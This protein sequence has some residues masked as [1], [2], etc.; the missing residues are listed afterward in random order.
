MHNFPI[1][2]LF[3]K[4]LGSPLYFF[5]F[6]KFKSTQ[7]KKK[8]SLKLLGCLPGSAFFKAIKLGIRGK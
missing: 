4:V 2:S 3:E 6:E 1:A 5:V 7:K 8:I